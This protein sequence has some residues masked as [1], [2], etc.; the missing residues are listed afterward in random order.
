[1]AAV[2]LELKEYQL[3][4]LDR[5]RT[6]LRDTNTMGAN[7]AFYKA[8]NMAYRHAP[9]IAEGTPYVC[10]RVPT[11]G[12]KTLMA[13]HTVGIAS[14][15]F[16]QASNPMALWLVP[17]TPILD[18]TIS[19]LKNPEHPYRTALAK[20]F[21]RNVSILSK[22]EALTMSRADAEGGACIIVSTIQ[23]FRREKPSGEEDEEGLKVYQD[24]G[25]LMD[26]FTGLSDTQESNLERIN[27]SARPVASLAN[28]LR[29]H[30]PMVI[31]DEAHNARTPLSFDTLARFSPSMILE[32]T[33]T[34]Q[35]EHDPARDKHASNILYSVSA[36]E[37]KAEEMIKMPIKLTTDADWRKTIGAAWDCRDALE[38][39]AQAEEAE[40]GEYIRPL[41]LFQAQSASKNDPHR[42]TYDVIEKH[43][44]E[45]RGIS[46]DQIAVH[47]GPRKDLD[48]LDIKDPACRVRYVITVQKLKEG[49]DCPFAYVLCSVA[50]QVA[51]TAIEQILGRILRMPKAR[52]KRRDA[53]NQAYAFVASRSFDETA[54]SLKD[55]LVDGAGFNRLEADQ[56][57]APQGNFGLEEIQE[58]FEHHSDLI[59]DD[60]MSEE[61]IEQAIAKLPASVRVR[62]SFDATK[63]SVSYKGP[64][65]KENRNILQLAL[66]S[67]PKAGRTIEKLYA[68]SNNFQL[69]ASEDEDKP[70]FVVP[71]LGFRKQGELQ[72][73]SKEHFLDLPWRL[74][75]C[76]PS[77]IT[78]RF[79]I[80][81]QSQTGQINVSN[82]GKIEIDFIKRVQGE[83]TAVIQ[84]PAWTLPRLANWLDRG[85]KHDDVTKPSAV[86][87]ITGAIETLISTGHS[88]DVLARNKYDLRRVLAQFISD[89]RKERE[90]GNYDALFKA[91]A[92]DFVTDS[93]LSIIF[94]ELT[95]AFNQP[96]SGATKFNKHYTPLIGDLKPD[97]EEFDCAVH[98]DRHEDVRYW[99]RNVEGK[100]SSFWL[101]LPHQKF[102]PDFVALL[103]DGRIL[104]VEY[105]GAHLYE[106]ENAK[107]MIG[108]VWA[109]ASGGKCLF[110]MP[111]ERKFDLI[112]KTIQ[113]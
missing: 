12:G 88:L 81:D 2:D 90:N 33:A 53:L 85:I 82:K 32:L 74:D 15:E 8:T 30:R 28:L 10:L 64:M 73:F 58:D 57:V 25:A 87:F 102:Y 63:K 59:S 95:Y 42:L 29:L 56:I 55:G 111:T 80:V 72:L 62:V 9:V 77:D 113:S 24:A 48:V 94:D 97:G 44:I 75:E 54:Q 18:Q 50:E 3:A 1:M 83:L 16:L 41:I 86:L 43:L 37:L 65:T 112:D 47:T 78:N 45:E 6:Y 110:C 31:V 7:M 104:V 22:A 21:G 20:D 40:T 35:T 93:G 103:N 26:H 11:G 39:A 46:K 101:Q 23:S 60:D 5:L 109:E 91:N 99:I 79:K 84:E 105:K 36:A 13:A 27:G 71:Q 107:R 108:A 66:A 76:E 100:K 92:G 106:S 4:A 98:I 69:S 51:A 38:K 17:S 96:Y 67:S 19:A 89:L 49:W 52:R 61:E 68:K 34:P 70:P 14:Q